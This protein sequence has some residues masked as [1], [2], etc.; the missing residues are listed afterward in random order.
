MVL[1]PVPVPLRR[2]PLDLNTSFPN[3]CPNRCSPVREWCRRLGRFVWGLTRSTLG[4]VGGLS[5]PKRNFNDFNDLRFKS[6]DVDCAP[7][8]SCGMWNV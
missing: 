6:S 2:L 3:R 4:G 7:R 8:P 5:F 1:V